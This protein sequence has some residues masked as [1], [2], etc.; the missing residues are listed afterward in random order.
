[1][2]INRFHDSAAARGE[3]TEEF[4]LT[5]D[6]VPEPAPVTIYQRFKGISGKIPHFS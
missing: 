5:K 3:K 4:K 6:P 1:M 2:D